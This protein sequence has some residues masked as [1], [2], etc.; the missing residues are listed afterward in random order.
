MS[1]K[2]FAI[3]GLGSNLGRKSANL[4]CALKLISGFCDIVEVSPVYK[5]ESLLKDD[6]ESYFNLC[7]LVRSSLEP[8]ELLNNL[9]N[10]EHKMGRVDSGHWYTRIIDIDIIDYNNTVFQSDKLNIPHPQMSVRSFVLYPLQDV[11]PE[12]VHP[13]SCL[14]ISNMLNLIKDNLGIKRLGVAL[15]QL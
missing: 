6:Q 7:A 1:R 3:L 5:T 14:T 4:C 13:S 8:S 11:A 15:W 9:K 12:Y 2:N 10:I